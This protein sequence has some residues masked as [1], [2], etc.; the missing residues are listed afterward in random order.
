VEVDEMKN[1]N[2]R[3]YPVT[4]I[5]QIAS[6]DLALACIVTTDAE[7]TFFLRG[8]GMGCPVPSQGLRKRA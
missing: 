5:V 2:L 8:L 3:G 6:V 7:A 1:P 4:K